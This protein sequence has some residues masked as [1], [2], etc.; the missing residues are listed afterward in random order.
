[1]LSI[2]DVEKIAGLAK[3]S[4][5]DT[6]KERLTKELGQIL[7]FVEK[8]GELDL[9]DVEATSHAVEV[10]NVFRSDEVASSSVR[11]QA[12]E[13]APEKDGNLFRVPR[14]I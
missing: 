9:K 7:E 6:E 14:I 10:T 4:L 12:L 1:M 13:Q 5:A 11:D 8:L 2:K 3:L